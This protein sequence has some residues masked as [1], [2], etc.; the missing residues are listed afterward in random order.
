MF[1]DVLIIYVEIHNVLSKNKKKN[2]L[3]TIKFD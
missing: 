3:M 2:P 1:E